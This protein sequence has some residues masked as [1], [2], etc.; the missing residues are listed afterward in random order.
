[1]P[2]EKWG[3][4]VD[5]AA[6]NDPTVFKGTNVRL[7]P[8]HIVFKNEDGTKVV[9]DVLDTPANVEKTKFYERVQNNEN[10]ST[11]TAAPGEVMK[12]YD[13]ML[14]EFDHIV[15]FPIPAN[16]SSM[17]QTAVMVADD[18]KYKGKVDV[19]E[20]SMATVGLKEFALA[21]GKKLEEGKLTNLDEVKKFA[22]DYT[23]H[24]Y[25]GLVP[26]DLKRF[27]KGGRGS[28]VIG[29]LVM[30]HT[31]VLVRWTE[32]PHKDAMSR[33]ISGLVKVVKK[34]IN[35]IY[36]DKHKYKL[37]FVDTPLTSKKILEN[38]KVALNKFDLKPADTELIGTLYAAHTGTD[39]I[40]FVTVATDL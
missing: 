9:D 26:G 38:A 7:L 23:E 33:S 37:I 20:S 28:K 3:V 40:G 24:M 22:D 2:K 5:T 19:V 32:K 21:L 17:Y 39:T 31:K 6:G 13:E 27:A 15:H 18:P 12:M 1:M 16:L 14:K 25:L 34:R 8:L 11:S 4:L 35:E 10:I 29:L 36:G 30:F